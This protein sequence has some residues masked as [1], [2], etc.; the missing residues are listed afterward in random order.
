MYFS[1]FVSEKVLAT[2]F[3]GTEGKFSTPGPL[4]VLKGVVVPSSVVP[5]KGVAFRVLRELF[6]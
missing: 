1:P 2:F 5:G 6:G 3:L 4:S